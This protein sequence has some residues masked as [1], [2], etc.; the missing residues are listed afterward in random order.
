[1]CR[2]RREIESLK[3]ALKAEQFRHFQEQTQ[4]SNE[5]QSLKVALQQIEAQSTH[6]ELLWKKAHDNPM[7]SADL[8]PLPLQLPRTTEAELRTKFE[9]LVESLEASVEDW[10]TKSQLEKQAEALYQAAQQRVSEERS[11]RTQAELS[12]AHEGKSAATLLDAVTHLQRQLKAREHEH[13]H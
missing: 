5:V 3:A 13:R 11:Q 2:S 12:Q 6:F 4:L 8:P 10:S 7:T 9:K 1:M